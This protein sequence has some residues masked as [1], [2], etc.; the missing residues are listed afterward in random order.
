MNLRFG[1]L[2]AILLVAIGNSF[3]A[4]T[5]DQMVL[6]DRDDVLGG[7]KWIYNDLT[8]G[9]ADA[10]SSGKPLLSIADVQWVLHHAKAPAT[11]T[12]TLRRGA[13][14]QKLSLELDAGWR[15]GNDISWRVS[16]WDLRRMVSGGLVLKELT[17]DERE[18]AGLASAVL[19]L[20]VDYVGQYNDHAAGKRAGFL[21][22]DIVVACDDQ[23]QAMSESDWLQ[24]LLQKRMPGDRLPVT[25]LRGTERVKLELP[26]Q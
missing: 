20:R 6:S 8:K 25:V 12:A 2:A 15:R 22:N 11:L 5:R 16:T 4:V 23:D 24:R 14:E 10:R 13:Q 1:W 7:G 9:L 19:G 18:K 21:K 3:A 17:V 26:M